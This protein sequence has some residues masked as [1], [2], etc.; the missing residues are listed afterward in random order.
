M[1]LTLKDYIADGKLTAQD[2]V[3][4]YLNTAKKLNAD[5][6]S[7]IRFHEDYI[8]AH[9]DQF[10]SRPLKATPIGI[11]DIIMTQGYISSCGSKILENY[12][13]PYS[14]TC[15]LNLEKN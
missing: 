7:F 10:A 1:N 3:H 6:F 9:L 4:T 15:I 13:S 14:A 8:D 5:Y 2:V 12:V 11:K